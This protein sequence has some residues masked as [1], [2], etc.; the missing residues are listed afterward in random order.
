MKSPRELEVWRYTTCKWGCTTC[1]CKVPES[2]IVCEGAHMR[3]VVKCR[4]DECDPQ[5]YH[6]A[7]IDGLF[8]LEARKL[9][10]WKVDTCGRH[11]PTCSHPRWYLVQ[12]CGE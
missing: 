10:S 7:G 8:L 4:Q 9:W 3:H 6:V 1:D 12:Y 5:S 11:V 2:V